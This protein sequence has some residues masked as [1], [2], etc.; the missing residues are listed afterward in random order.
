[1]KKLP[2][3]LS[4]IIL[5]TFIIIVAHAGYL[6][7]LAPVETYPDD[8]Y[9]GGVT[10]KKALIVVAHD[11]E[12][13]MFSGTTYWL[14]QQGWELNFICFYTDKYRPE[15]VPV[16]K[17]EME[18]VAG[19]LEFNG[20][21]L[22]DYTLRK[23]LDTISEPWLPIPYSEFSEAF[24]LE[25]IDAYVQRAI[26]AYSPTVIFTLDN[27][28]G[29]YGH[30]EHVVVSDAVVRVC[31]A[32]KDV[33]GFSVQRIYQNVWPESQSDRIMGDG[34]PYAMGKEVY[35]CDGM[36][37]PDV[38]VDISGSGEGKM[39]VLRAHASQ[40]RNLKKFAPYYNYYPGWLYF[41]IFDK[42][43]FRVLDTVNL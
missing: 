1:M 14:K 8:T 19:L 21:E 15:E 33:Q 3:I 28:I 10:E 31:R 40:T 17:K 7:T 43:H 12:A 13:A 41:R 4:G 27:V 9:L 26:D 30:P 29:G 6:Y 18:A 38:Q 34:G 32:N 36:P 35:G 11:D 2:R 5:L 16:R 24:D 42:E 37:A 39:A 22:L 23:R 20:M 25:A